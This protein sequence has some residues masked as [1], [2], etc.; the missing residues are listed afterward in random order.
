MKKLVA[1]TAA[2]V[3]FG[4]LASPTLARNQPD[5]K[6]FFGAGNAKRSDISFVVSE[7]KVRKTLMGT[8]VVKCEPKGHTN[9]FKSF[10]GAKIKGHAFKRKFVIASVPIKF[11]LAGRVYGAEAKGRM[12]ANVV[13]GEGNVC[14][15]G[16]VRW[17]AHRVSY[18]E[19]KR[20]R[21]GYHVQPNPNLR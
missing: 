2:L 12:L 15:S 19:W 20:H 5:A 21:H 4:A 17:E 18:K 9:I 13:Y 10:G 7:G 11:L 6:Y 1:V 3:A 14:D 8:G 16:K